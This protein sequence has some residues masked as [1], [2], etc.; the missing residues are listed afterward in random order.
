MSGADEKDQPLGSVG[1]SASA[2][3]DC[4]TPRDRSALAAVILSGLAPGTGHLYVGRPMRGAVLLLLLAITSVAWI[5]CLPVS[6]HA[7]QLSSFPP[8]ILILA[9][10]IDSGRLARRSP[11]PYRLRSWQ[12]WWTYAAAIAVTGFLAPSVL[13]WDMKRRV[14]IVQASDDALDPSVLEGDWVVMGRQVD[15]S[16]LRR[17]DVVAIRREGLAPVLRRVIGLPGERVS[18]LRGRAEVEGAGLSAALSRPRL[19]QDLTIPSIQLSRSE[20]LVLGDRRRKAEAG[21]ARIST[22]ALLGRASWILLPTDL[23]P[24]RIGAAP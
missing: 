8:M 1:G 10:I 23:D 5:A 12:R 13:G 21:G 14:A 15:P 16:S 4:G 3:P 19:A 9:I 7:A 18:V 17:G 11:R 2:A 20:M 22:H 6:Y 24:L